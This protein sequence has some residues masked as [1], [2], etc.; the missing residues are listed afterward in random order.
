[1]IRQFGHKI[2]AS[3][4]NV[5]MIIQIDIVMAVNMQQVIQQKKKNATSLK[6]KN[7]PNEIKMNNE[8]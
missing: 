8:M 6:L 7:N 1:M 5:Y 3:G 4:A 2:Q